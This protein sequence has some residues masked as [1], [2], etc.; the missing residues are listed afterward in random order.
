MENIC[1]N[2]EI[3]FMISHYRHQIFIY[4][5]RD[6]EITYFLTYLCL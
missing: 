6:K 4:L 2:D 5:Q 3:Y 1:E